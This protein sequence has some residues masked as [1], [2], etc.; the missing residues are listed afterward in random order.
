VRRSH[1]TDVLE[2]LLGLFHYYPFRCQTCGKRFW[3]MQ[4][5]QRYARIPL[6]RRDY[7]R[8][9]VRIKV[10]LITPDGTVEAV[11]RDISLNGCALE[12]TTDVP[13]TRP[14]ALLLHAGGPPIRV[15]VAIARFTTGGI[16]GVKFDELAPAA[17]ARLAD[18]VA[19]LFTARE[20]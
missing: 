19:R 7:D 14:F 13:R 15:D 17:R 8:L 1:R 6:E 3:H 16:V 18:Y 20:I 5:R 11:A 10:T 2:R 12:T 9:P 4:W